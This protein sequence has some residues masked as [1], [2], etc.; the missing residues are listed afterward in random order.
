MEKIYV[1]YII[2]QTDSGFYSETKLQKELAI[3]ELVNNNGIIT[4]FY[5]EEIKAAG[6]NG[7]LSENGNNILVKDGKIIEIT[8]EE[9]TKKITDLFTKL[10][11]EAINAE[12]MD[13]KRDEND[14]SMAE[15]IATMLNNFGYKVNLEEKK[16]FDQD[17]YLNTAKELSLYTSIHLPLAEKELMHYIH[18]VKKT[19][20]A[21]NTILAVNNVLPFTPDDAPHRQFYINSYEDENGNTCN[22]FQYSSLDLFEARNF[23]SLHALKAKNKNKPKI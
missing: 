19:T 13:Y 7:V 2:Y 8:Q 15:N 11:Y 16:K 20:I 5:D 21:L 22:S 3:N 23:R 17:N 9:V 14:I 4:S 10:S 6:L 18:E 12:Y 1:P